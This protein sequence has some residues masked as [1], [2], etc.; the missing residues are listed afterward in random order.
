MH[1]HWNPNNITSGTKPSVFNHHRV[2]WIGVRYGKTEREVKQ[3]NLDFPM[4]RGN[5]RTSR[6][7]DQLGFQKHA[8]IQFCLIPS[9]FEIVL[10][11]AVA[12]GAVDRG[13]LH[14]LI[15][16][17]R[18]AEL[19]NIVRAIEKLKG[20][21]FIWNI[22]DPK[23]RKTVSNFIIDDESPEDFISFYKKYDKK[24]LIS[25]CS[26]VVQP[27]DTN[28]TSRKDIAKLALKKTKELLPLY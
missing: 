23:Q 2:S 5:Y 20:K 26:F 18:K 10:F 19:K 9:G 4:S 3:L 17:N 14:D 11:Y 21:G 1:P 22:S 8:C 6:D 27:D 16:N 13:Y 12:N 25:V 15:D 7:D 28:L 24:G